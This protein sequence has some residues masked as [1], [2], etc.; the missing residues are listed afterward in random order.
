MLERD[1]EHERFER[2]LALVHATVQDP[3]APAAIAADARAWLSA[4][5]IEGE[6]LDALAAL[7]P[8]RLLLYRKLVRRGLSGAIRQEIPRT[9]ARLGDR[10]DAEVSAWFDEQMPRSHYLRDVAF[11]LVAWATPR[12][13]GWGDDAWLADLARHEL[14]E[15]EVATASEDEAEHEHE[16]RTGAELSLEH[17][18]VFHPAAR[19]VRYQHAV[20]RLRPELEARDIPAREA[21]VLLAYRDAQHDVRYLELTPLAAAIVGRLLSGEPLGAAV[22]AGCADLGQPLTDA[23]LQGTAGLLADLGERGALLGARP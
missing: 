3:S 11:E 21:T 12:W 1:A 4:Q 22:T 13:Q 18:V 8:A 17:A 14:S 23:V 15:F 7:P 6:D 5:G 10:F 2:L 20:H 19:V 16:A 9:A